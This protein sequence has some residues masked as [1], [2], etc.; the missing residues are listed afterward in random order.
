MH[1]HHDHLDLGKRRAYSPRRFDTS[2]TG[3]FHVHNNDVRPDSMRGI[4]H[5]PAIHGLGDY[6]NVGFF[7]EQ[8]PKSLPNQMMIVRNHYTYHVK[9]V[10]SC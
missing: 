4:N 5:L 2:D 9:F 7:R 8:I 6:L 1:R 3:H 10:I